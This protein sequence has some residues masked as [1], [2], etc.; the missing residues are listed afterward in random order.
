MDPS[1]SKTSEVGPAIKKDTTQ[2]GYLEQKRE[3]RRMEKQLKRFRLKEKSQV[4]HLKC[5][6]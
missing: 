4:P 1:K 2:K 3:R 6:L 5:R